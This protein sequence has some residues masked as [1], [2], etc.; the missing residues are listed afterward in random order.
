MGGV[1]A[2][3]LLSIYLPMFTILSN[4]RA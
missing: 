4:I 2:T 3:L 1:V